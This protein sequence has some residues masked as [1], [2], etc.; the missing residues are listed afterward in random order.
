[1]TAYIFNPNAELV[2]PTGILTNETKA[3]MERQPVTA[4]MKRRE[5]I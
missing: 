2:R 1:M 4:K 5:V 3:E